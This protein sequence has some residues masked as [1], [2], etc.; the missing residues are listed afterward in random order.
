MALV[1]CWWVAARTVLFGLGMNLLPVGGG[2]GGG[3]RDTSIV[4]CVS[5]WFVGCAFGVHLFLMGV[6]GAGFGE[7]DAGES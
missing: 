6:S 1:G 5:S 3:D 7:G 4:T 2:G